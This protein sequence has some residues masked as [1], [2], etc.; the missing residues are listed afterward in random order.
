MSTYTGVTSFYKRVDDLNVNDVDRCRIVRDVL[1]SI[2][3][4]VWWS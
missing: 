3:W 4:Q 2:R 1:K